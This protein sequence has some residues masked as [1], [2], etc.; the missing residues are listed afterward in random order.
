M[1]GQRQYSRTMR[2]DDNAFF[3]L[4]ELPDNLLQSL[5]TRF[6]EV[7]VGLIKDHQCRIAVQRPGQANALFLPTRQGHTLLAGQGVIPVRHTQNHVV[8]PGLL[9]RGDQLR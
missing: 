9:C 2:N 5:L 6:I 3:L 8:D 1:A 4:P 7:S